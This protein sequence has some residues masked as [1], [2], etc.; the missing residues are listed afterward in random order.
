MP[1]G[2]LKSDVIEFVPPLDA[3][4]PGAT[5]RL[6]MGLLDKVYL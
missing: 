4:R 3:D 6:G 1:L 2:V 5:D